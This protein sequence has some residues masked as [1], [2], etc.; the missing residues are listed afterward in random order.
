MKKILITGGAG[1]IGYYLAK[2]YLDLN[3]E[4]HLLDNL[5]R[6]KIDSEL[7]ILLKKKVKFFKFDLVQ[8]KLNLKHNYTYIFHCAA[9]IGV[10]HVLKNPYEVLSKNNQML[11]NMINFCQKQKFLKRF[12][13]FSTSE[14]YAAS[15]KFN[16]LKFPTSEKN[17][18][19]V[20]HMFHKRSTYMMSKIYGEYLC[21]FSGLPVTIFRPHNFYGPRMGM[22][23]VIPELTKKI[24]TSKKIL[25]QSAHHL[26]TFF[27]IE[28]AINEI[29]AVIKSDRSKNQIFNIGSQNAI[30]IVDLAKKI[31]FILN[32]KIIIKSI[33]DKNNSPPKRIPDI[34]KIRK[35]SKYKTLFNLTSGLIKTV[36]WYVNYYFK[37]KKK[38]I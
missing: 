20:D 24:F 12:I 25:L 14:V 3:F 35:I 13:F 8:K 11:V 29:I 22:S 5:Q 1:F 18:I 33:R 19:L 17:F 26:R 38:I 36:N 34:N 4:V 6:G 23:H 9:I 2:K 27:Y 16:L 15:L 31:K 7:K 28:D 10:K 32:K 37:E 30:K 21:L